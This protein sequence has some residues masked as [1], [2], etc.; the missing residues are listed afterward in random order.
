MP[1]RGGTSVVC[2]IVLLVLPLLRL[3]DE[4]RS[5]KD[6]RRFHGGG[7]GICASSPTFGDVSFCEEPPA[8]CEENGIVGESPDDLP[9]GM[10]GVQDV[11][12]LLVPV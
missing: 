7:S 11:F 2:F 6:T 9:C 10:N 3:F 4:G 8:A 12:L 5:A 1:S